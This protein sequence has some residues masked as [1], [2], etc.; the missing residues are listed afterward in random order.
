MVVLDHENEMGR[1]NCCMKQ[2]MLCDLYVPTTLQ[3]DICFCSENV[4]IYPTSSMKREKVL[5]ADVTME[6]GITLQGNGL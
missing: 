2:W 5:N 1:T 3:K 6:L 4:H